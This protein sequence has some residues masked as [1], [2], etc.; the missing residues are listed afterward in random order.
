[1][2]HEGEGGRQCGPRSYVYLLMRRIALLACCLG[3]LG[4]APALAQQTVA[5]PGASGVDEYLETVPGAGGNRP[6][7]STANGSPGSSSHAL[8]SAQRRAL[9][10]LGSDGR[11]AAALA[12]RTAPAGAK[13]AK[14][15][16]APLAPS[17]SGEPFG[18]TVVRA[19]GGSGG[20]MGI[21]L[22]SFLVI[23]LLALVAI[24][25]RRRRAA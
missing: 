23:S 7:S 13:A 3:I 14:R 21:V 10:R 4:T 18:Q 1:M 8:S 17:G 9:D 16:G 5:P 2:R 15:S 6:T 11:K 25:L 19:L 12:Q 20:G 24:G 22:P